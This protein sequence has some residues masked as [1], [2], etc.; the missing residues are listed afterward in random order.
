MSNFR[1]GQKVVCV[2]ADQSQGLIA[3]NIYTVKSKGTC[4]N[5]PGV[6]LVEF[7]SGRADIPFYAYRFRPL[8][9]KKTNIE[10]F[11]RI[12]N[13]VNGREERV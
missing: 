5:R 11:T 2:D 13:S 8:V 10:I 1:V 3:G 6:F 7:H 4:C 12:L 9:E